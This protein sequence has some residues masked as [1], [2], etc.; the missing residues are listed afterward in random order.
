MVW[1]GRKQCIPYFSTSWYAGEWLMIEVV[2]S[3]VAY[4]I[5]QTRCMEGKAWCKV[6]SVDPITPVPHK[7]CIKRHPTNAT[8][9]GKLR[10]GRIAYTRF[11]LVLV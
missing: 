7:G 5:F 1:I 4:S 11:M 9:L 3:L 6:T 2:L 8:A 10:T